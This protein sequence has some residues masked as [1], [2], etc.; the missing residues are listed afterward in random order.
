MSDLLRIGRDVVSDEAAA[1]GALAAAL[2]S[3]FEQAVRRMLAA[4]GPLVVTGLGKSGLIARKI[5]ATL[6]STGSPAMYLHPV[7][8]LHGDLGIVS[9]G[10]VLLALSKSGATDEIIRFC[11]HFKR[12]GGSLITV[13]E[14]A[15]SPLAELAEITIRI[16]VRTE[17]GPLALAPTT[18]TTMMLALG[19]AL[20]MA[21]LDARGF[22]A[23]DFARFHPEGALGKRLL[24][25]VRDL[26]HTGDDLPR[27]R[28]DAPFRDVLLEMTGKHIGMTCIIHPDGR[29]FGVFTDGDLRR[30]LERA[31]RPTTLAAQEAW[32]LSRRDPS[33]PPVPVSTVSPNLLVVDCLEIMRKSQITSLV[34]AEG[35]QRPIGIIRLHDIVKAGLA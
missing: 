14:S 25:R 23:D 6:S 32:R 2:D 16:P 7:E 26:M 29:L 4:R 24:L 18:S 15:E 30:L 3:S 31:E 10:D 27:V 34:A 33:E 28:V 17:A 5:A 19:D 12:L 1:L 8:G 9:A 35:D 20:A 13:C 21:L 22:A 11:G